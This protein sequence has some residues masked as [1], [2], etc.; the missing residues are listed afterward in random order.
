MFNAAQICAGLLVVLFV[1][2]IFI[3]QPLDHA[4]SAKFRS[5]PR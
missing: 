2:A 3:R 5:D 1:T 4:P